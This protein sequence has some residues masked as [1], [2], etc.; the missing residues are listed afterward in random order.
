[1][2]SPETTSRAHKGSLMKKSDMQKRLF[3]LFAVWPCF[4]GYLLFNLY[5]NI[6]SVYYSL[7]EWNGISE[8]K[9]VG[10][11]NFVSM[12]KDEYMWRALYHNLILIVTIPVLTVYI[13]LI[14]AYL[15]INKGY[16]EVKI[17][18]IL[19]FI[20][21]ILAAIVI[22]LLWSF[23]Y[24]GSYGMLNGIL[25]VIGIDMKE[26]YWLG[27]ERTAL[28]ALL[29]PLI[30][31]GVGLYVVI[32]M[33]AMKSIPPSLYEAA[34]LEGAN[35]TTRL[36]KI[37]IPL[38]TPIIRVGILFLSLGVFKGFEFMLILTNGGPS[39]STEVIG[40]YMFSMAFGSTS[41]NY[42]YA[43]AIGMFLFVI[44]I[45]VKLVTDRIGSK[46]SLEY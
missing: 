1:M 42:G 21:N 5:P 18:R 13:S 25:K 44:L 4:I 7:L 3:V 6:V 35:H 39:G 16:F 2:A 17:Y 11:F 15:L 26:Y 27:D 41:H 9:F 31:S 22:A 32:F 10:L 19:F 37:T 36:F 29:P 12:F 20:P 8:A 45:V 46:D 43:S 24:D 38:L 33:N 34:V 40:L 14:L 28:W 30:W 23:I